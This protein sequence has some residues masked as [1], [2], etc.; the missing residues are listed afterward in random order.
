MNKLD[1]KQRN[2]ILLVVLVL[3]VIGVFYFLSSKGIVNF[4]PKPNID[5]NDTTNDTDDITS[6]K[7]K[8][9]NNVCEDKEISK[10]YVEYLQLGIEYESL[11]K[12]D[13]AIKSYESASL[14]DKTQYVP[15]SNIGSVYKTQKDFTKAEESFKK[16]LSLDPTAISVYQKLYELYRYDMKKY[17]HEIM[18][19]FADAI[20]KTGNNFEVVK[21]YAVYLYDVKDYE[22]ALPMWEA[23][24]K[25]FPDNVSYQQRVAEIKGKM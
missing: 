9:K 18:P 7:D 16:A 12:M 5:I 3:I 11:G 8:I 17:P 15:Y 6:I 21:M 4:G 23:I 20:Q 22:S 2:S 24:A 13:L 19:F 14:A 1:T 25:E 10:C